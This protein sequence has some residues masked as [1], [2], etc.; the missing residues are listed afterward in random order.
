MLSSSSPCVC[1]KK[2]SSMYLNHTSGFNYYVSGKVFSNLSMERHA[3]G[4]ANLVLI[5]VP[6]TSC[7]ILLLNS[8]KLFFNI[9]S[10]ILIKSSVGINFLSCLCKDFLRALKPV[11]W[12]MLA[13]NPTTSAV[14][15]IALSGMVLNFLG[16]FIK[17][18]ESLINDQPFC[19]IGFK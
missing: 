8:K 2:I 10:G 19:I 11:S 9:N 16:F 7:L 15:K 4:S 13:Y 12:G 6:E 5:T 14:T 17:S 1:I 18:L 3:C